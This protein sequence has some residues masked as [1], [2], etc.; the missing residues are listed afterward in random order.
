MNSLSSAHFQLLKMEVL[1]NAGIQVITPADCKVI[2]LKI[3]SFTKQVISETTVKRIF[4]FALSRFNPSKY[5][6]DL[7]AQYSGYND[8]KDF[9]EQQEIGDIDLPE[10][11]MDWN[12]IRNEA[13]KITQFTLNALKNR[14]GIPF[15][16]TINRSF[17]ESH[18]RDFIASHCMGT[19]FSAP[20]GYGKS[21]ALSHWVEQ[22]LELNYAKYSDDI[23][24]F[25]SSHALMSALHSGKDLVN[26]LLALL[27]YSTEKG[28]KALAGLAQ[29]KDYK[30]Y[31][32][33]D[34][35]DPHLL[36]NDEFNMLVSQLADIFSLRSNCSYFKVILT[37]RSSTWIN[38]RQEWRADDYSWFNNLSAENQYI[39]V[40]LLSVKEISDLRYKINPLD[41]SPVTPKIAQTI[42]HPLYFQYYYKQHKAD[43]SLGPVDN[44][45]IYDLLASFLNSKFYTP[46][47]SADRMAFMMK[48]VEEMDLA[49]DNYNINK[50]KINS[51][52][53]QN[54][55]IYQEL[56]SMGILKEINNSENF[57]YENLVKFSDSNILD[58]FIGKTLLAKSEERFDNSLV[59]KV[60][61]LL[62]RSSHKLPVLKWCVVGVVKAGNLQSLEYLTH[63]NLNTAEKAELIPYLGNLLNREIAG[64]AT[65]SA[66]R[67]Y[68]REEKSGKIFDYFFGLE[69]INTEYKT[70]LQ[71]LLKFDLND[72]QKITV[73]TSLAII[74]LVQLNLNGLEQCIIQMSKLPADKYYDLPVDP[75]SCLDAV[76]HYLKFGFVKRDAL[77][78]VTKAA[79]ALSGERDYKLKKSAAN[80]ILFIL[81]TYTLWLGDNPRKTLRF[82]R[83]VERAYDAGAG[84]NLASSFKFFMRMLMADAYFKIGNKSKVK[85]I[86]DETCAAYGNTERPLTPFMKIMFFSLKIKMFI[87]QKDIS[88]L[89][90]LK[91]VNTVTEDSGHR[92]ARVYILM[93]LLRDENFSVENPA[94]KKQVGNDYNM[95]LIKSGI[96]RNCFNFLTS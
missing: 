57:Q 15:S 28:L 12:N 76:Y 90:D 84:D 92:L 18:M 77:A 63:F 7:L 53:K 6:T 86:Y 95:M 34:G 78:D 35:F 22:Q 45:T 14:S 5:T 50:L 91:N 31:L 73:Y 33:I 79:F 88:M 48:L 59:C 47:N 38:H 2:S 74:A 60:N 56:L 13:L 24:L 39:N 19:V 83:I 51:L 70:V 75:L 85:H 64:A 3:S 10:Q 82:T 8:W 67:R 11:N 43:F 94:F 46:L 58:Y 55:T 26:W 89:P 81:S 27:G 69:L 21:V 36:K 62:E 4:G 40:P 52:L 42:N 80:D 32:I 37:M 49:N 41:S 9:C 65:N 93:L 72:K 29:K 23:I 54:A 61:T 30:F 20:T 1:Q 66:L 68:F 16:Q 96:D 87:N 71:T 17:F 25:F 44:M